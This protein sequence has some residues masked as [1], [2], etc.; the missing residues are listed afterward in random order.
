MS[1]SSVATDFNALISNDFFV[2]LQT[3][4]VTHFPVDLGFSV[5]FS[6]DIESDGLSPDDFVADLVHFPAWGEIPAPAELARLSRIA[7]CLF[8]LRFIARLKKQSLRVSRHLPI[9]EDSTHAPET[10]IAAA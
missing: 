6:R 1:N 2:D 8:A 5:G 7:A 3:G 9:T 10:D 4:Y